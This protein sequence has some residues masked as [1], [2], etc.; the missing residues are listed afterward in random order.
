MKKLI[1]MILSLVLL[2]STVPMCVSAYSW[3]E[4][5]KI[6]ANP[7]KA[8]AVPYVGITYTGKEVNLSQK[9]YDALA[10]QYK[11]YLIRQEEKQQSANHSAISHEFNHYGSN[12]KYHWMECV[13]GCKI[14]ME[15]HVDP[16]DAS[17]D[18]CF[19][20]YRFSDNADLVTLWINGCPPIKGFSKDKT[21]YTLNAYTYKDVKEIDVSTRTF[22]SQA[23]VEV[24]E[25]LTLKDGENK[26]EIK[27][28]SENQKVT[29]IYTVI[30]NKEAK[31]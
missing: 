12:A 28:T 3:S 8:E 4:F 9:D 18:Y 26:F 31:K 11:A 15:L 29:K 24:P 2:L 14:N 27:V 5:A 6:E 7:D 30:I 16:K 19:C 1:C 23:V 10:A 21:E 20:G 13:C 22:D 17:D 25:D